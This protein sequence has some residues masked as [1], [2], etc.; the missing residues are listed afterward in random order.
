[1]TLKIG[2]VVTL[3]SGSPKMTVIATTRDDN[4]GLCQWFDQRADDCGN[5]EYREPRAEWWHEDALR[6][7]PGSASARAYE[8]PS[9]YTPAPLQP[10]EEIPF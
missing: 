1:M 3:K 10:D 7:D 2:D 6:R 9:R 4:K 8:A 5:I